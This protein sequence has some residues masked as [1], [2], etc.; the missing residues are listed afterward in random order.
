MY[1]DLKSTTLMQEE[2]IREAQRDA[3]VREVI[4]EKK[5][6]RKERKDYN[7]TLAWVG[8]RIETVGK[9]LIKLSGKPVDDT[10]PNLN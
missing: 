3:L 1:F 4:K 10:S 8:H 6:K 7:P 2:R 9:Q 5:E